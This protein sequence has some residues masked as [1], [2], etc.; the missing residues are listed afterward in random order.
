MTASLSAG[1]C[2][3]V[4]FFPENS[5]ASVAKALG[6]RGAYD[7][8]GDGLADFFTFADP[9]GR[10]TRIAYDGNSSGRPDVA[11]D[12]DAIPFERCRHLVIILDGFGYEVLKEYHDAGGLA[13]FHAPS[14]VIAPYPAMSDTAI[15]DLLGCGQCPANEALYF[16]RAR[17]EMVGGAGDYLAGKNMPYNQLLSYRAGM[18]D[19][20]LGYLWP[21]GIFKGEVDNLKRVFDQH[22]TQEVLAYFASSA[23]MGTR[24]GKEGQVECL[25]KLDQLINQIMWETRGM[26]RVTLTADHGHSY[27]PATRIPLEKALKEKGWN[28]TDKLSGPKDVVYI[29]FGLE[30]YAAFYTNSPNELAED[31]IRT[32]GVE[33]ASYAISDAS[34]FT[35]RLYPSTASDSKPLTAT[36]GKQT[37]S[38]VVVM[39]GKDA[40]SKD[41]GQHGTAIIRRAVEDYF[42]YEVLNG[43]PLRVHGVLGWES[44]FL[45]PIYD[46]NQVLA[47]TVD[48]HYPAPLERLWRAHFGGVLHPPDV[49]IS[50]EDRFYSGA[51]T[52]A[53]AVN[54]ASTHGGLNRRNCTAFIM[55]T[56]GA[57]P[58]FM[59]SGDVPENMK[60]M[61]GTPFPA[62][63]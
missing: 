10:I 20:A 42:T 24:F 33:L 55:S 59:R 57:L 4:V 62:R 27:T 19:D 29:R 37:D 18:L 28:V 39:G 48:H 30:T 8:N 11:I 14:K 40:N 35:S 52:F 51:D 36:A 26:T 47:V 22:K 7:T 6:A 21:R 58:P 25:R 49:I 16:D 1:G 60:K 53:G 5:M 31:L 54:V 44:G 9:N 46:S 61:T 41:T 2:Q 3:K 38:A 15:A 50:L 17:N 23:G 63:R 45:F 56:A 34:P 32:E 13:W 12:L 43:D